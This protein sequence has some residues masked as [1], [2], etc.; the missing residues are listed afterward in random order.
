MK[1]TDFIRLIQEADRFETFESYAANIGGAI[2]TDTLADCYAFGQDPTVATIRERTGL[3]RIAFSKEYRIPI[4]TLEAWEAAG[5]GARTA[6]GYVV[7]MLAYAAFN[8]DES[9][10]TEAREIYVVQ[11]TVN[12]GDSFDI[13]TTFDRNEALQ[14]ADL[15]WHHLTP[16]ERDRNEIHVNIY[17]AKVTPDDK[18]TAEEIWNDLL[19]EDDE[20]VYNADE[21]EW[22]QG[23]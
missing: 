6:P 7:E 12:G 10:L 4:R 11:V 22:S 3:N 20:A 5:S 8:R 15:H 13:C 16:T 1:Y 21:V 2:Q 19:L 23:E 18:R 14:A 17:T 9:V